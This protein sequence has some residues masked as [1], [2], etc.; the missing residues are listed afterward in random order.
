LKDGN[1]VIITSCIYFLADKLSEIIMR[2]QISDQLNEVVEISDFESIR[3]LV[4]AHLDN[5]KDK[6]ENKEPLIQSL[7]YLK[8]QIVAH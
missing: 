4:V 2:S 6:I 8:D 5:R 7:L 3:P 1:V